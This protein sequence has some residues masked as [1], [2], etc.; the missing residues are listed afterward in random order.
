MASFTPAGTLPTSR[1]SFHYM[2]VDSASGYGIKMM[3]RM[4][5]REGKGLGKR[6]Q[7]VP[8]FP[9]HQGQM[10]AKGISYCKRN[11]KL[12][13]VQC[14]AC[15]KSFG[16]LDILLVH[17]LTRKHYRALAN[18]SSHT[19]VLNCTEC[20]EAFEDL[21][22]LKKHFETVKHTERPGGPK[23][24]MQA[25][26]KWHCDIC[27]L[28]LCSESQF[29]AHINGKKHSKQLR[30]VNTERSE[31]GLPPYQPQ[32]VVPEESPISFPPPNSSLNGPQCDLCGVR[33]SSVQQFSQHVGSRKHGRRFKQ[34][35]AEQQEQQKVS[36]KN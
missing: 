11:T 9:R 5:F 23:P 6:L 30:K 24:Q 13:V 25:A 7:G 15:D 12:G 1:A 28:D 19:R 31:K 17:T 26:F 34:L 2:D 33:T 27:N 21:I 29:L 36:K 3:L 35:S 20:Y 4:G 18:H 8:T 10:T 14:I 32:P 16:T 22:E